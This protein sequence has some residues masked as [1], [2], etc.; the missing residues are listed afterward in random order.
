MIHSELSSNGDYVLNNN[1]NYDFS[2]I[3][4]INNK[5]KTND[6]IFEEIEKNFMELAK[7]AFYFDD[8]WLS[9][10]DIKNNIV[11]NF[12]FLYRHSNENIT[13]KYLYKTLKDLFL[14]AYE[15]KNATYIKDSYNVLFK[16]KNK[17]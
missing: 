1:I 11:K 6:V 16:I 14:V 8:E 17:K 5:N 13:E 7:Y 3:P 9:K 4:K 12:D 15:T 10:N 2:D